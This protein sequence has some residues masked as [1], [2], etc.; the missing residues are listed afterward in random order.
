MLLHRRKLIGGVAASLPG[1]AFAEPC[2]EQERRR[3]LKFGEWLMPSAWACGSN[4]LSGALFSDDF[5]TI[6]LYNYHN[7]GA[8]GT[9]MPASWFGP[10]VDGE[11]NAGTWTIN[12]F[13]P[14]TPV[15]VYTAANSLLSMRLDKTPPAILA[16]VNNDATIGGQLQTNPTFQGG[17]F[18]YWEVRCAIPKQKGSEFDVSIYDPS[19][20]QE[21]DM[22]VATDQNGGQYAKWNVWT[23]TPAKVLNNFLFSYNLPSPPADLSQFH[24]FG[25]DLQQATTAFYLDR[26]QVMQFATPQSYVSKM[27]WVLGYSN[28]VDEGLGPPVTATLPSFAM[29][30]YAAVWNVRPF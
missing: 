9:W 29:I 5:S 1:V 22:L 14:A 25:I 7:P 20:Q 28:A 13:N 3:L 27:F 11:D 2:G 17:P 23:T 6:S 10:G 26:V 19:G 21:L 4:P 15:Q 16:A 30:D 8:G 18:G 12:P 24:T